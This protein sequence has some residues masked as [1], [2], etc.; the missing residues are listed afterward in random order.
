MIVHGLLLV[1]GLILLVGG[2]DLLV[3]GASNLARVF[4]VPPLVIGLTVVAFGTSAPELAVNVLAAVDGEGDISFGNI[5]GSNIAN[6]GLIIGC[7]ALVRPLEIHGRVITREIPMMLLATAALAVFA[8]DYWLRDAEVAR[9]DRAESIVLLLLFLV[10]V[11]YMVS[12]VLSRRASEGSSPDAFAEQASTFDT[13]G[14]QPAD[15]GLL[16][17]AAMTVIGLAALVGG[18]E[19]T[20]RSAT[21]L[22]QE[23]GVSDVIIGLTIVALGTSLPELVTGVIATWRGQADLAVGN[24]VGSNIFNILLVMGVT[25]TVRPVPVP[26]GGMADLAAVVV[27]SLIILPLAMTNR[28]RILRPEGAV[29]LL[30]YLGYNIWRVFGST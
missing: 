7:C 2:G 28:R 10:F 29:L 30:G 9:F 13:D 5:L 20:V 12:D 6:I 8:L 22:A 15:Q 24:V 11:F 27:F 17:S 19:L 25:G 1:V 23:F 3:R 26:E 21:G 18:G 16:A 14:D 4:G